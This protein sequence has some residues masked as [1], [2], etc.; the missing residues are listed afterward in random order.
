MVTQRIQASLLLPLKL[1]TKLALVSLDTDWALTQQ[2]GIT[3][4]FSQP[5]RGKVGQ[6]HKHCL[7]HFCSLQSTIPPLSLNSSRKI[8]HCRRLVHL[9]LLGKY[10]LDLEKKLDPYHN[11]W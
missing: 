6:D 4:P 11:S 8:S 1:A 7:H 3:S 10:F 5:C 9:L 2:C